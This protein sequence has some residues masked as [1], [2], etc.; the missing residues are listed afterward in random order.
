[1]AHSNRCHGS[2]TIPW[3]C[4]LLSPIRFSEIAAP[5]N[6]L[7]QKGVRFVWNEDCNKAFKALKQ[8]LVQAPV[9][10]YPCFDSRASEFVLETDASAVGLG[11]V[12][13]QDDH[14][15]VYAS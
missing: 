12:L 8:Q 5:L 15:I 13:K 9:M 1:M 10:A 4:I 11:A 2:S 6:A 7:T 3:P 14:V